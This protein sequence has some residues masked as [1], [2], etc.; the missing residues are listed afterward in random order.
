MT[1]KY[2]NRKMYLPLSKK[3][4]P[5]NTLNY[6]RYFFLITAIIYFLLYSS[7][8]LLKL[9][10]STLGQMISTHINDVF[11]IYFN[12]IQFAACVNFKK[13]ST[14][15]KKFKNYHVI[16]GISKNITF[17][18]LHVIKLIRNSLEYM[19]AK[20]LYFALKIY[21]PE[22]ICSISVIVNIVSILVGIYFIGQVKLA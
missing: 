12:I 1:L 17:C 9:L 18:I 6:W 3:I 19:E 7:K 2:V 11:C 8:I 20:E 10:H 16:F 5:T 22:I 13:R 14:M 15:A 4:N 21:D